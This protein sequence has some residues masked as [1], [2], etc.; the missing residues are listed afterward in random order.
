M[1]NIH[2]FRLDLQD[3]QY[4]NID[5]N[6]VFLHV[7]VQDGI[8]CIWALVD[9]HVHKTSRPVRIYGTGQT[10]FFYEDQFLGTVLLE[11]GKV[12][13]HIFIGK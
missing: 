1:R 12:V 13:L 6:A 11:S 5:P 3:Q 4:I 10:I 8:P 9:T 2:K 7:D